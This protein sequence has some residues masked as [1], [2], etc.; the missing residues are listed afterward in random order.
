MNSIINTDVFA[1][2]CEMIVIPIST[3]ATMSFSFQSGLDNRRIKLSLKKGSYRLGDVEMH[4]ITRKPKIKYI[5]F[6]CSVPEQTSNY[7]ALSKLAENIAVAAKKL[8]S[9]KQIGIPLLG[10]GAGRLDYYKSLSTIFD[11]F[12]RRSRPNLDLVFCIPDIDTYT[13]L[14]AHFHTSEGVS[15]LRVKQLIIEN[16]KSKSRSLDLGNCGLRD[17]STIPEL[18]KCRHLE[19]LILSNEWGEYVE[20]RWRRKTSINKGIGNLLRALPKELAQLKNLKVLICGGDWNTKK[21]SQSI[22]NSWSISD[23]SVLSSLSHLTT[24]NL[25]NNAI[26]NVEKIDEQKF[27]EKLYLNNNR[28]SSFPSL[29]KLRSLTE[30]YLSNNKLSDVAFLEHSVNVKTLDLHSNEIAD[31]TPLKKIISR[32][33][34]V[35]S[36]WT[37]NTISIAS[38]PLRIPT[39]EIIPQGKEKVIAYLDQLEAESEIKLPSFINRDVKLI[40]VGNSNVGKSTLLHWL[41]YRELKT[42]IASTHW[43]DVDVWKPEYK[44]NNFTIRTFDFGGQEYYHDTHHLFFTN[45][46]VYIV[47]WDSKTEGFKELLVQ[48]LQLNGGTKEVE[49][50]TYPLSYWLD[51]IKFHT[52]KRKVTESEKEIKELLDEREVSIQESTERKATESQKVQAPNM[53]KEFKLNLSENILVIQNKVDSN[54]HRVFLNEHYFKD[55]YSD[56]FDFLPIS[57]FANWGLNVLE[58]SLLQIF[59]SIPIIGKSFLKTWG[60][61]KAKIEDTEFTSPLSIS[62]FRKY[63]NEIISEMTGVKGRKRSQI[64]KILFTEQDAESFAKY[65]NDIGIL[66][67]FPENIDLKDKAFLNQKQILRG[68]YKILLGL[69]MVKGEFDVNNA[70]KNLDLPSTAVEVIDT[71]NL[72]LHFKIIFEHP[73]K[74]DTYIAPLYL[75]KEP[76]ESIKMFLSLFD[77]PFFRYQYKS[78]I[79]KNVVLDFFHEYG[80]RAL[81]EPTGNDFYYYWRNGIVLKDNETGEIIMVRFHVGMNEEEFAFVDVYSIKNSKNECFLKKVTADLESI[82]EGW[83]VVK[84]VSFNGNDFVPIDL[85]HK[86]EV[87][88]NWIFHFNGKVY[89]L[90]DFKRYLNKQLKMKK[91][92]V[93]YS[94]ADSA[95]LIKLENHLSVLKKNGTIETWNC[96]KLLPG[97][98]WDGKIKNELEEADL[99]LFLISD[100]FLATD[101]I[102]DVEIKRAIERDNDPSDSVRVIPIIVR[103]CDWEES[104]LGIYNTAPKK[105]EIINSAEDIDVAWTKVVKELK[106]IL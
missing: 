69:D 22:E 10:T 88:K 65:L 23:I 87:E 9:V 78:F 16:Q 14:K 43:L 28:I 86:N 72:M 18:F 5:A 63:C 39:P 90:T 54:S 67:Y 53:P 94:K 102:W 95:H 80:K 51:S 42:N 36:K 11:S 27:L 41:K 56:I 58:D 24:L 100:D 97:E 47:L 101:Y 19:E 48:Q 105:A 62:D 59:N 25:S 6:A 1:S 49:I 44:G 84:T 33:G 35:D 85:I 31:L 4:R 71:I 32:I 64:E 55:R 74:T 17:L 3:A 45:Q 46:T 7:D 82:N 79:H 26:E 60:I 30:V 70:A 20:G 99:I 83:G 40:L 103:S 81:R 93:S 29:A 89:R 75:P 52:Q 15:V 73:N 57:V 91:V 98:K 34:I 12:Y 8:K 92:F 104:P 106:A 66:L 38:N 96:R 21:K 61:I 77:K 50:Q 76:L 13:S 2:G 68:I 37:L